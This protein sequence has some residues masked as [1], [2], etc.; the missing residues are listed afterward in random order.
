MS[1]PYVRNYVRRVRRLHA[2]LNIPGDHP[3][4]VNAPMYP[5]ANCLI[6][7]GE[8]IY[9]REQFL[10]P[11][12]AER[13]LS[14]QAQAARDKISLFIVSGFRS[15]KKQ[16]EIIEAKIRAGEGLDAILTVNTAPG[17]SQHH[18]GL[19]VDVTDNTDSEPLT[20]DFGCSPAFTWLMYQAPA[21]GFF[22]PYHT[23]N[24]YGIVYEPWHWA[25]ESV[26]NSTFY[27]QIVDQST[28]D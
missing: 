9:G 16:K 3:R 27:P 11:E 12:A 21:F 1:E 14:L 23:G 24:R 28:P 5:E 8:D 6:S 15:V 7:V 18:T 26:R 17:Y 25:L 22:L 19:V 10:A 2:M 4:I 20:E 13:W